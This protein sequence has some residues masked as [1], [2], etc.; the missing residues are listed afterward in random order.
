MHTIDSFGANLRLIKNVGANPR[1]IKN[2]RTK[3][4]RSIPIDRIMDLGH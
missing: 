3:T 4:D 1:L 2:T